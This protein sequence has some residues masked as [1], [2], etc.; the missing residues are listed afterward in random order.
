MKLTNKKKEQAKLKAYSH[1]LPAFFDYLVAQGKD[2]V[3][4]ISSNSTY[5]KKDRLNK[6]KKTLDQD[7]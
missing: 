6:T 7:S 1:A 2:F 5:N 3:K 4:D